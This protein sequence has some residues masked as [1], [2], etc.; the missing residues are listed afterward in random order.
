MLQ[1]LYCSACAD[2]TDTLQRDND[3]RGYNSGSGASNLT[4]APAVPA[5]AAGLRR[6]GGHSFHSFN[7]SG[8]AVASTVVSGL[9]YSTTAGL[10]VARS[11]LLR[12]GIRG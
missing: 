9:G 2:S 6:I 4:A 5:L 8:T 12:K 1:Q 11:R 7:S 3:R 10:S